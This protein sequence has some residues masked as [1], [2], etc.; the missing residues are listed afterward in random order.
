ME[1]IIWIIIILFILAIL[2]LFYNWISGTPNK[3]LNAHIPY[4]P[5]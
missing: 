4:I 2:S 3:S 5:F 1:P